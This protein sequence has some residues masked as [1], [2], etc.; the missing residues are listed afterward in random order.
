MTLWMKTDCRQAYPFPIKS[1]H[2]TQI[3]QQGIFL[4]YHRWSCGGKFAHP[5]PITVD[6]PF[7][8]K[9]IHYLLAKKINGCD[10]CY[11]GPRY[12][13]TFYAWYQMPFDFPYAHLDPPVGMKFTNRPFVGQNPDY[14]ESL[15]FDSFFENG[16]LDCA[17]QIG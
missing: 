16:N 9:L 12:D 8:D 17:I 6:A 5:I 13:N 1:I 7:F 4:V 15:I 14:K 11:L 3:S 10:V 2:S